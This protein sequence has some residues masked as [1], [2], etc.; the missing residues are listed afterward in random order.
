M[1]EQQPLT[2]SDLKGLLQPGEWEKNNVT[3]FKRAHPV[4]ETTKVRILQYELNWDFRFG[5]D[6]CLLKLKKL[7]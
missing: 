2:R 4:L 5:V 6:A 7:V 3:L 1:E